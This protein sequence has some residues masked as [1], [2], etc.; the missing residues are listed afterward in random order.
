MKTLTRKD[1]YT[2]MF[3]TALFIIAEIQKYPKYPLIDEWI[4][5]K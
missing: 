2:A 5:K 4:K 3:V 1:M